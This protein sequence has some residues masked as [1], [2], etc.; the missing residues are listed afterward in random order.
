MPS[1]AVQFITAC[2]NGRFW[3]SKTKVLI[4]CELYKSIMVQWLQPTSLFF[5]FR[6]VV[7]LLLYFTGAKL[8]RRYAK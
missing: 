4:S 1:D 8:L 7:I 6:I 2:P 5:I 3:L